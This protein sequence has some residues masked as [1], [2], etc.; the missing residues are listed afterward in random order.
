NKV[1]LT[2]EERQDVKS[3]LNWLQ[4]QNDQSETNFHNLPGFWGDL[5][6][7]LPKQLIEFGSLIGCVIIP[8]FFVRKLK[9]DDPSDWPYWFWPTRVCAVAALV[10]FLLPFPKRI[11]E[12]FVEKAPT[13]LRLSEP[14]EL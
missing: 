12:L 3:Q 8:L 1:N 11:V 6:G 9:L 5:F 4:R 14:Q 13:V 7:K 2:E 10:A